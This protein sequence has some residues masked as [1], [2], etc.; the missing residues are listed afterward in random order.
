[1]EGRL[2]DEV[3]FRIFSFLDA[4]S[5]LHVAQVNKTW[6]QYFLKQTR[7]ERWMASAKPENFVYKAAVGN[8]GI[9]GPMAYL[10]GSGPTMDEEKSIICTVS[11]KRMLFAWD[12]QE[13]TMI[14][15]SPVQQS[16]IMHL[17]TLPQM[18]LAFTVDLKGAIKVWNCRDEDTLATLIMSQ[19][20]LSLE[21]FLTKDDPFLMVGTCEGDIYTLTSL[22]GPK[23]DKQAREIASFLLPVHME[24][25]IWMGVSDGNTIVFESGPYLFLVSISG[26]LLQRFEYHDKTI[27]NLWVDSLHVLTTS[28]D[29]SLHVY[30]WEEEGR[31]PYLRSCCHLEHIGSDQTPSW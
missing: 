21:A 15:S 12:V 7:Q 6:K 22:L 5:L 18:H 4:S 30:M 19:A 13:G 24:S 20:C 16:S 29:D 27:C 9:L 31:Y 11:S 17:A 3:L 10:S 8:L 2:P 23:E 28:V 14:W 1:M 26:H 25:P